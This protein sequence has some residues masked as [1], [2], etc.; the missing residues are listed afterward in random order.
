MALEPFCF[1]E[2][3]SS[4]SR[5]SVRW[6]W[7]TLGGD[8]V[9]RGAEDG[10]AGDVG[11]VAVALDD[12]RGDGYGLET[13]FVADGFFVLGL[14]VAEGADG[15]GELA[16]AEVFGGGV[17]A[18]EVALHLGVPE[19]ELEAEGGG[20]GV[21]AVGA[22]D[23][24]GVLELEGAL[25][26]GFGEGEDAGADD[27]GGFAELEGLRGVD[28]VGG[29][30]AVVEPAGGFG[31]GDV[32][33]DGGGEGDDVVA[34]FGFDLVDAVDGEVAAVADG[35]G[36]GLGDE[37]EAGEGLR[38]GDF[39][40]E[41][42]AVLVL[43]GPDAA[44]GGACVAGDH[45]KLPGKWL[46]A[47]QVTSGRH[48][49]WGPRALR[50]AGQN[51]RSASR[52]GEKL[53][54]EEGGHFVVEEAL[55]GFV[56]LDP[57]SVEDELGDGALA[58]VGDDWS[59][60][61][62]GWSRCR[63]LCRGWSAGR[64]SAWPRGSRG[65]RR[66]SRRSVPWVYFTEARKATRPATSSGLPMRPRGMLARRASSSGLLSSSLV[67]MGVMMAPGATLLT[68]IWWGP[69][70]TARLRMSMRMAPLEAA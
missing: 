36:G 50:A 60:A 44:H 14:E 63:S 67:L 70:S 33:G 7:R 32:F 19:E 58:D 62:G 57:F 30:E 56:G 43:V 40:G 2:K 15:S 34:D 52:K 53:D 59:A 16:D 4:A 10:E 35:V 22:A 69:S 45:R 18:G 13:E 61:P 8:L 49:A 24:G 23:D 68:V 51:V 54:A 37:A 26:E 21:D 17:E 41:P 20:F 64:G 9:E 55:A 29:G 25:L 3:N 48:L 11:G 46:E 65:T 12:L 31:V 6:R 5:T 38:G 42:A 28:D 39:D 66:R 47:K 1:S 27:G